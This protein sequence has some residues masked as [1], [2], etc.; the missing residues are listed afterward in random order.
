MSDISFGA[1]LH[2]ASLSVFAQIWKWK[3]RCQGQGQPAF[4]WPRQD[5]RPE[6]LLFLRKL[7]KI[8][9]ME[10]W[11]L[12]IG[13]PGHM[14]PLPLRHPKGKKN[15]WET[16]VK[17]GETTPEITLRIAL[18]Q[19]NTLCKVRQGSGAQYTE[20]DPKDQLWRLAARP[21]NA[22]NAV[23]HSSNGLSYFSFSSQILPFQLLF[24]CVLSFLLHFCISFAFL[25]VT[26]ITD[27]KVHII[28]PAITVFVCF[29]MLCVFRCSASRMA[30]SNRTSGWD[31][32]SC[33][34]T[35]I[36]QNNVAWQSL[37]GHEY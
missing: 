18:T 36:S 16:M 3:K 8:T 13:H 30:E 26:R 33:K 9:I 35:N 1:Y 15:P 20:R 12:R 29:C 23:S 32:R 34:V 2:V 7:D 5:L 37:R 25:E 22:A 10:T 31:W 19:G 24:F 4:P 27:F 11:V 21:S 6:L 28:S 17:H 14:F